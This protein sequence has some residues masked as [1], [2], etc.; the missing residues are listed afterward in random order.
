MKNNEN[1]SSLVVL[2][3]MLRDESKR[4]RAANKELSWEF[5][6]LSKDVL[7]EGEKLGDV[8]AARIRGMLV[9]LKLSGL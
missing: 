1:L 2:S 7:G 8:M 9:E 5:L 6:K 3:K 4:I